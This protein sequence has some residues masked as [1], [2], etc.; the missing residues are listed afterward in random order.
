MDERINALS[1]VSTE[2][3]TAE[4]ARDVTTWWSYLVQTLD[5]TCWET[6]MY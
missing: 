4:N 2:L 6:F 5:K 3:H 1:G